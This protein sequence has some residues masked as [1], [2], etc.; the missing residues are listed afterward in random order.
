MESN[1]RIG[2][3]PILSNPEELLSNL[4]HKD[5][6]S[7]ELERKADYRKCEWLTVRV[8]LKKML[9]EEKR[10]LY[11]DSGK[12]FLEDKSYQI[13]ISHTKNRVAVILGKEGKVSIDIE[14]V[15]PRVQRI[16]GKFMTEEEESNISRI[17]EL[18]HLL[19]HWSAKESLYKYLENSELDFRK[20]L[21]IAPFEPIL[22]EWS[23]FEASVHLSENPTLIKIWYLAT[24][25]YVL[26]YI[27][28]SI[29]ELSKPDYALLFC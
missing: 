26:T 21:H 11:H 3:S 29:C 7:K 10:I 28:N 18:N 8:L 2:I 17:N 14:H 23:H 6:Y 4:K 20:H 19:L 15:A 27:A 5:W 13:S 22:N 25:K 9:G 24:E 1:N 12:P 16:R